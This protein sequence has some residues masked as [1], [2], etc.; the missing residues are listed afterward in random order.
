MDGAESSELMNFKQAHDIGDEK[1]SGQQVDKKKEIK[2]KVQRA[3]QNRAM[4]PCPR[5]TPHLLGPPS[6]PTQAVSPPTFDQK[7]IHRTKVTEQKYTS[8]ALQPSVLN[9]D[10]SQC[11]GFEGFAWN[12]CTYVH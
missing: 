3:P 8:P 6:L 10:E 2:K 1:N 4:S 7:A 12:V 5:S 11:F 9:N